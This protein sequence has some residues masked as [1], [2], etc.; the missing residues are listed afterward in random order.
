[1]DADLRRRLWARCGGYCEKCGAV[2][3]EDEWAAHHRKFRGQQG[4]DEIVNLLAVHH[5]C[6]NGAIDS[7][8]LMPAPAT[9]YGWIVNSWEDP[10]LKPVR[11]A[12]TRGRWVTLTPDGG[13]RDGV[14]CL[15][16][17]HTYDNPVR[18]RTCELEDKERTAIDTGEDPHDAP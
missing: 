6:H 2:M 10:A 11:L 14:D 8:H 15:E 4:R 12:G 1:V 18:A 5:S 3:R 16:C 13:Y 17:G 7:I 9:G